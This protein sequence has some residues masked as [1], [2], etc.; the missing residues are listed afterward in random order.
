MREQAEYEKINELRDADLISEEE[1][2]L[3][4]TNIEKKYAEESERISMIER[5]AKMKD[6]QATLAALSGFLSNAAQLDNKNKGLAKSAIIASSASA[7]LG[8]WDTWLTKDKTPAPGPWKVAG[9]IATTASVIAATASSLKSLNSNSAPGAGGA[10]SARPNFN[11]IG[12]TGNNQLAQAVQD[13]E[14]QRAGDQ[15]V[16]LVESE[17]EMKQQDKQVAIQQTSLG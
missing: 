1:Y 8:A 5:K 7:I 3:A 6:I 2:Q 16:V 11:I 15:R 9:A 13:R 10:Q 14:D 4:K 17:L 12:A